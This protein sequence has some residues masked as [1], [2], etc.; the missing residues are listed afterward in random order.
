MKKLIIIVFVIS[1]LNVFSQNLVLNPSFEDTLQ[2]LSFSSNIDDALGW[3]SATFFGT[4]EYFNSCSNF[5][6]TGVPNNITGYQYAR[7][8]N[9]YA[10]IFTYYYTVQSREYILGKLFSPLVAERC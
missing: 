8:G 3:S 2:S 4:P 7:T 10:G 9:A 5:P 1:T 6:G